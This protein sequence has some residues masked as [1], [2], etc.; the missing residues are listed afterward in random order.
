MIVLTRAH[1][2][3]IADLAEQAYPAECCGLLLGARAANGDLV[4]SRVA[5]SRNLGKA[6]GRFEIDPQLWVDLTRAHRGGPNKV[7]G[8]Y[9]SHPDAPAQPSAIDLEAAWGEDLVW[10]IVAVAGGGEGP[11]QAIHTTAHLLDHGGRQF[12]QIPLRTADW[13]PWPVR[14]LCDDVGP[15]T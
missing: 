10:L 14:A 1:L 2:R 5:P 7:V 9:H 8:L 12:R 13:M 11:P 15:S 3:Q 4:V 6:P